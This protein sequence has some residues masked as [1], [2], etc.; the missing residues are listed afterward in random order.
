MVPNRE[1]ENKEYLHRM[2]IYY[3]YRYEY[4]RPTSTICIQSLLSSYIRMIYAY[5][6]HSNRYDVDVDGEINGKERGEGAE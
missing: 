5:Q 6:I 1:S 2:G 3:E 4:M